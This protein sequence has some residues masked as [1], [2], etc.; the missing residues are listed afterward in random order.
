MPFETLYHKPPPLF[1]QGQSA[2]SRFLV[3]S[4]LALLLMVAD[5]RFHMVEQVRNVVATALYPAQWLALRP[6][7]MV[8]EASRYFT[9]LKTA[10]KTEAAARRRL[11]EQS[12]RAGQV[13]QLL[14]ENRRL[15]NLLELQQRG[16]VSAQVAQVLYDAT[17]P[18]SRRVVIGKGR[19]HGIRPGSPVMD[20]SGVLG[21]VT[22]VYPL[23]SEV[24][25]LIDRQQ[26]TPVVNT[27]SGVRTV[28]YGN[29]AAHANALELR[30]ISPSEDLRSGD[31]LV[32]SGIGGTYPPGLPVARVGDIMA[33][34]DSSFM[35]VHCEPLAHLDGITLVMVLEPAAVPQ[36]SVLES[37]NDPAAEPT[38]TETETASQ[39]EPAAPGS[40]PGRDASNPSSG[41]PSANTPPESLE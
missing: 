36:P 38:S 9:D 24:T 19:V 25:L 8:E 2:L 18:F 32:T 3:L 21:Q 17:D 26:A 7:L 14:L 30:Y 37:E 15:R 10:R 40:Q 16:P 22:R 41:P 33:R 31:L 28:A 34:S 20:E 27:R 5:A 4:A 11:V 35:R 12:Q 1:R 23:V 6:V 13:E 29:S 39:A